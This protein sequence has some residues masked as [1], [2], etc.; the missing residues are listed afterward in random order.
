M[1]AL[2]GTMLG[3]IGAWVLIY[4]VLFGWGQFWPLN[5]P[6][7]AFSNARMWVGLALVIFVLQLWHLILPVD[8]RATT[9]VVAV[10]LA[11]CGWNCVR[12]APYSKVW[13]VA[14]EHKGV[15]GLSVIVALWMV[16]H[17]LWAPFYE[18]S[19]VYH[20]QTIRWLNEY[21]IVPGLG[22]LHGR[23]A[24]NQSYFL[25][26]AVL[27]AAPFF[28]KGHHLAN[29][30]LITVM[31]LQ[32]LFRATAAGW[33][34]S[35]RL[36][37]SFMLVILLRRAA[38]EGPSNPTPDLALFVLG[39]LLMLWLLEYLHQ[40]RPL[41]ESVLSYCCCTLVVAALGVTFKLSF[42]GFAAMLTVLS[43][44]LCVRALGGEFGKGLAAAAGGTALLIACL[45]ATWIAR[46][47]TTSGYP[48]YPSTW[49]GAPVDWRIPTAKVVMMR[50]TI[51]SWGRT[52]IPRWTE[53]TVDEGW[54]KPWIARTLLGELKQPVFVIGVASVGLAMLRL[55][56][57]KAFGLK[58]WL[59]LIAPAG[60]ILYWFLTA[61]DPR[62]GRA[63]FW[64]IGA[65]LSAMVAGS[66]VEIRGW[67]SKWIM[68]AVLIFGIAAVM[69]T[70]VLR[71]KI[72]TDLAVSGFGVI[73]RVP[74]TE[75]H[76]ASGLM[77]IVPVSDAVVWDAPL[78]ST[79]Y[80]EQTLELRG[81]TLA[82]GF[83]YRPV[84]R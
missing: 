55:Y 32:L 29:G 62:F 2:A 72:I 60:W 38:M 24:F 28:Q 7:A 34:L 9:G 51:V 37:A 18:D 35:I 56:T 40:S 66:L 22:N 10:G 70:S 49:A 64:L 81:K 1:F 67:R 65:W 14:S 5:P 75:Y 59:P 19:G 41:G 84:P 45:G 79:P 53:R 43:L 15:A 21:P 20:F 8:W 44:W 69:P 77:L 17:C 25:F 42:L 80:P 13:Q 48:V 74:L 31:A 30:F 54:L 78:P 76:T 4:L 71:K 47:V 52:S 58:L 82:N 46:G 12:Y 57:G 63:A 33:T 6:A 23:L 27:N 68:R 39:T 16:N 36:F 3:L 73:P 26:P 61:P 83:R 50:S 11:G